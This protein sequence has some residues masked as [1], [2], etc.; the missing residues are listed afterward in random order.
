M[1]IF[2]TTLVYLFIF[3]GFTN[4]K[5]DT[6][7]VEQK[8]FNYFISRLDSTYIY[9]ETFKKFNTDS[10]IV[11]YTPKTFTKIGLSLNYASYTKKPD[12]IILASQQDKSENASVDSVS[13]TLTSTDKK[14]RD[15]SKIK[16]L[17]NRRSGDIMI[18][19]TSRIFYNNF[20]YVRVFIDSG[21]NWKSNEALIKL[22]KQGN[23]V[24][25]LFRYGEE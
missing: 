18:T 17:D 15:N 24:D 2:F 12:F 4:Q 23:P 16:Y 9:A 7:N 25:I 10:N 11:Y 19:L 8:A 3:C 14:L 22:D 21:I 5:A 1:K 13:Y 20:F 6:L